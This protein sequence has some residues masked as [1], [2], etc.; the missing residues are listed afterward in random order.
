MEGDSR[1]ERGN[2]GENNR[3]RERKMED[4][5]RILEKGMR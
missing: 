2:N 1:I 4:N 5:R 3:I